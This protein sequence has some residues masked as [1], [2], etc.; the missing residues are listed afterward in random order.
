MK[1]ITLTFALL[2]GAC[3]FAFAGP[4]PMSSKEVAPQPVVETCCF[5]GW[6]FGIHGGGIISNFDQHE[7]VDETSL[8][9]DL[10]GFVEAHARHGGDDGGAAQGG[11]QIGYNW[12]RGHLVWGIEADLSATGLDEVDTARAEVF[13]PNNNEIPY[14]TTIQSKATVPWYSTVRPR[15]GYVFGDRVMAFLTGGL[16]FGEAD[17]RTQTHLFAFR[18]EDPSIDRADAFHEDREIRWGWT[19][20]GGFEFCLTRHVSL[21]FTYLYVDLEAAHDQTV[22][23]FFSDS[24]PRR[25]DAVARASTD[26]NFHVFQGGINI[27]F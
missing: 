2:C 20:G 23:G 27:R 9:A 24:I 10:N 5:D 19:G 25:F 14:S 1:Q 12:C 7:T 11:L 13:L 18:D 6:Y 8:G 26:N 3:A 16:A 21:A 15:V 4:E 22:F 17:L